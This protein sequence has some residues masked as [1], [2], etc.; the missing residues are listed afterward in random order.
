MASTISCIA[1]ISAQNFACSLGIEHDQLQCSDFNVHS[2]GLFGTKYDQLQSS[3]LS[4]ASCMP[5]GATPDQLQCSNSG[6]RFRMLD[7]ID[8]RAAVPA[9][10]THGL[11]LPDLM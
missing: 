5:H 2:G 8:L 7:V 11:L 10:D 4:I 1:A 6:V 3:D 9:C